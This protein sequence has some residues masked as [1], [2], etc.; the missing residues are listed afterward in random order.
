MQEI[1]QQIID[2]LTDQ[3][4]INTDALKAYDTAAPIQDGDA[5]VKRMREYEAIRLRHSIQELTRHIAVIR[6]MIPTA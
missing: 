4:T 1:K 2:Y 5:E 6:R 3:L